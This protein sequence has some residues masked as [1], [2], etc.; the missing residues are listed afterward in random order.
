MDEEAGEK[1]FANVDHPAT[2]SIDENIDRDDY[3]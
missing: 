1:G 3:K 2:E